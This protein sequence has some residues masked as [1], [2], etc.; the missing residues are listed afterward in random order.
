M[1]RYFWCNGRLG[2][3]LVSVVLYSTVLVLAL[4]YCWRV[5]KT[6]F[7]HLLAGCAVAWIIGIVII[8]L[9][10]RF[11][12]RDGG[13]RGYALKSDADTGSFRKA[14]TW[15]KV[16]LLRKWCNFN[17]EENL[18]ISANERGG[19]TWL[20]ESL[21]LIP[22]TAILEEPLYLVPTNPFRRLGFG[23]NQYIPED[24]NWPEAA[25]MFEELLRGKLLSSWISS[26]RSFLVA[27]KIIVKFFFANAL[28][29]WLTRNF[30]FRYAPV[31]LI[32][33]P[34]AIAA[35]KL[36]LMSGW[37]R[38]FTGYRIPD[39]RYNDRYLEH[40]KFLS[41]IT[42]KA[43][44]LVA[45][46]CM[47]NLVSLRNPRNGTD[48]ITVYYENLLL[49]PNAEIQR[50]FDHWRMPIPSRI[51]DRIE[52]P[53]STTQEATFKESKHRQ[54]AKWQSSFSADQIEKMQAVLDYFNVHEYGMDV[55]PHPDEKRQP[56][57]PA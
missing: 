18:I 2:W 8:G 50:I 39:C 33:H 14:A 25:A 57:T 47:A 35:S 11:F 48:W 19:S 43:E 29:P 22:R 16:K 32:R 6:P 37:D 38:E 42:T 23:W 53:S 15:Y 52:A 36:N 54:L 44:A 30:E 26:T 40:R 51:Y 5:I 28:L 17:P 24:A 55:V 10:S 46:W 12:G 1:T 45:E 9:I 34:F 7:W 3:P 21:R 56:V 13:K 20:A 27:D 4:D 41:G 49:N 31:C